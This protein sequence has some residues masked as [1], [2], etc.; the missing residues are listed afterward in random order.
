MVF[1]RFSAFMVAH[2]L[3]WRCGARFKLGMCATL[4]L[5][6]AKGCG[7]LVLA[8]TTARWGRWLGSGRRAAYLK[9]ITRRVRV[10]QHHRMLAYFS[11]VISLSIPALSTV[12]QPYFINQI[13]KLTRGIKFKHFESR[14]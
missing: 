3:S 1:V 5:A 9:L 2:A 12:Y 11:R 10:I 13:S 14:R 8:S 7:S 4:S 6:S